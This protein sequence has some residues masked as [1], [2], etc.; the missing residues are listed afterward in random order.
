MLHFVSMLAFAVVHSKLLKCNEHNK[1]KLL[2]VVGFSKV[3]SDCEKWLPF[4]FLKKG[5]WDYSLE[6]NS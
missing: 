4:F 2:L 6:L 3:W 5:V 1:M